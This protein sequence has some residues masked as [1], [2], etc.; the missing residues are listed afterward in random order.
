MTKKSMDEYSINIKNRTFLRYVIGLIPRTINYIKA[1]MFCNFAK[2]RGA[3]IGKNVYINFNLSIKA[4]KNLIV[5]PNTI[6]ETDDI[7]LRELVQIGSNVIINKGVKILRQSH[8]ISS[9]KFETVGSS[10]IIEDYVWITTNSIIAPS[11]KKI[12]I[13]AII[14]VSSVVVK[15]VPKMAVVGGNPALLIKERN[16]LPTALKIEVLQARDFI[17]YNNVYWKR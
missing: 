11:C 8:N 2:L 5:G 4:N 3:K 15:N 16:M 14:A 9:A 10:L 6:I 13:G 12:E 1:T 17:L 7:D